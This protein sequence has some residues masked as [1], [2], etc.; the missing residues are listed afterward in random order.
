[1]RWWSNVRAAI[2]ILPAIALGAAS[3]RAEGTQNKGAT[4]KTS[5]S[6]ETLDPQAKDSLTRMSEFL[7]ALPVFSLQ[8][9]ISREQ[10]INGDLKVQKHSSAD[11]TVRRPDHLK[12]VVI[13][14]DD[15]SHSL[16]YDGNTF[17]IFMPVQ[18]HYAQLETSG[19]I[20]AALDT[21]E[22]RYGVEF[23]APDFLQ[24]TS[25]D[26]F[27]RDLTAAGFVGKSHVDGADS[28]HYAYRTADVDY[29]IW[30]A[31]G[32]K[33]LP[34][35]LVI[36]SKK[37]PAQPEYTA[38]MTW[39]LAPKTQDATFA[40]TPPAGASKVGFGAPPAAQ[41]MKAPPQPKRQK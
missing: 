21:V 19:P 1:M 25:G 31:S 8:E 24:M 6:E 10:V 29:Q 22:S 23:P 35:K 18:N 33:P 13:A 38:L 3:S 2:L 7:Q 9:E 15:K 20:A 37:Q 41:G 4:G 12:A 39:D 5:G 17:T 28:D 30:I 16:F 27:S 34:L 36:T 26:E 32:D 14:D 11:V 40:F